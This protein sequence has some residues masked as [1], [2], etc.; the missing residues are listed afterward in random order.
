MNG[1]SELFSDFYRYSH[2]NADR[3]QQK[4]F[5]W[6]RDENRNFMHHIP[7]CS[8]SKYVS[9]PF[10]SILFAKGKRKF[11]HLS[12]T[13]QGS[14]R[15]DFNLRH[16]PSFAIKR[17]REW[18]KVCNIELFQNFVSFFEAFMIVLFQLLPVW[19]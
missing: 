4:A 15:G 5:G 17:F 3:M 1:N 8:R 11:A 12:S 10:A 18:W 19:W 6:A 7:T 16:F 2:S 13:S 9:G 14:R